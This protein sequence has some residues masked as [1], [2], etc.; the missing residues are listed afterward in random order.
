MAN[1]ERSAEELFGEA[2][3]LQ[4]DAR[5]AFLDHAC[6]DAPELRQFIEQL[7]LENYRAGSFLADPLFP[8]K[9]AA[10]HATTVAP[11][12]ARF[13]PAQRIADRF[14]IVRFFARGGMGEV[15][16]AKDQFLKGA[17]VALKI[18]RPEIAAD[19]A[20]AD[21]FEQEV[22]LARKVVHPNLCPIY[23]IFHCE[24]PAPAFLML[25]MRLLQGETLQARLEAKKSFTPAESSEICAQLLAGVAALH[26]AG[27]IH[28]DLKPNNVMLE[29]EGQHLN[30]SIMSRTSVAQIY[31]LRWKH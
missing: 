11:T 25:T 5:A 2:L 17:S 29:P 9:T 6:R 4:P 16:E 27:V 1:P 21:R 19:S 30:V 8:A 24:Q 7:L 12:P 20:S 31:S 13:Q 28:R 10:G 26:A 14:V 18:I 23:E 3:E 22:I 15:Y